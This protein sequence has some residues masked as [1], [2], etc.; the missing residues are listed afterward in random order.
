MNILLEKISVKS[1]RKVKQTSIYGVNVCL[2]LQETT[3]RSQ[4]MEDCESETRDV[5]V[6][7]SLV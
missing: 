3:E 5:Q 7:G 2:E 6:E 4:L 1:A